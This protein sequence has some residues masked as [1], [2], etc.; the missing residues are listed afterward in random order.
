MIKKI[1]C[2]LDTAEKDIKSFQLYRAFVYEKTYQ[3]KRLQ[4]WGT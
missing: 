4:L 1:P 3:R 2:G